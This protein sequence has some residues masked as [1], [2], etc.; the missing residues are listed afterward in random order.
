MEAGAE[1]PSGSTGPSGTASDGR[2]ASVTAIEGSLSVQRQGQPRWYGGYVKMPDFVRDRLKTDTQSMAALDFVTGGRVGLGKGSEIEIQGDGQIQHATGAAQVVV[3][4][5]GTMWAKFSPQEK[6][7]QVRTKTAVMA[8]KGT[9]FTVECGADETTTL[10]VLEGKV[11]YS[12]PDDPAQAAAMATEGMQ[13]TLA[14]KKVPVVKTYPVGT[15]RQ[16][17]QER[18][19]GLDHWLVRQYVGNVWKGIENNPQAVQVITDPN[20]AVADI[21]RRVSAS[22]DPLRRLGIQVPGVDPGGEKPDFPSGLSPDQAEADGS[23]LVFRWDPLEG[24]EEYAVLVSRDEGMGSLDWSARTR[25]TSVAY[26]TNGFPLKGGTR[27]FW[28][29]IGLDGKGN[30]VG[31]A[32]QT[33]FTAS[34][35]SR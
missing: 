28:R 15:L 32:G 31:K 20:K 12:S 35:A 7:F 3:L 2:V 4:N 16:R 19:P 26:P 6:P 29:V 9:E 22:L 34:G 14:L 8:V 10:S 13:I 33:F 30:P 17:L 5:G 23:G 24:C 1:A 11:A 21:R 25:G 27:Y 18:F